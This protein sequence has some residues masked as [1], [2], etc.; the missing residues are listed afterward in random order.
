MNED[1]ITQIGGDSPLVKIRIGKKRVC[2]P[3]PSEDGKEPLGGYG[4]S[5]CW[6]DKREA[7]DILEH[8]TPSEDSK[9]PLGGCGTSK[10]WHDKREADDILEHNNI[11][12]A[13]FEDLEFKIEKLVERVN[14]L[15]K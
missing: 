4:T 10:C 1:R 15:N 3:I 13:R 12:N 5:K 11:V 14:E 9:E 2:V 6:Y 8:T 7:D